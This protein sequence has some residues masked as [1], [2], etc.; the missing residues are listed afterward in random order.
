MKVAKFEHEKKQIRLEI[1]DCM[2]DGLI[3]ES[4]EIDGQDCSNAL[5]FGGLYDFFEGLLHGLKVEK[6]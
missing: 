1:E 4:L 6:Q 3:I 2:D 5:D